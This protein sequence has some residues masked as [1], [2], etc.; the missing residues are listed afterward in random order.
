M[1]GQWLVAGYIDG[2]AYR[3]TVGVPRQGARASAGVVA[4]SPRAVALLQAKEGEVI[5]RPH[6]A[7]VTVNLEDVDSV[8]AALGVFTEVVSR[9]R[10]D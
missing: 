10:L 7:P 2:V 6:Q 4:G 8:L 1:P 9:Q 5:R 3:V